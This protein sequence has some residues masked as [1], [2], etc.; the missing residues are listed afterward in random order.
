MMSAK[1]QALGRLVGPPTMATVQVRQDLTIP[2]GQA[3]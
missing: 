3:R 2:P 1:G